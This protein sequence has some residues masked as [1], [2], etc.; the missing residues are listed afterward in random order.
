MNHMTIDISTINHSYGR[1]KPTLCDSELGHHLA[2]SDH[3]LTDALTDWETKGSTCGRKDQK[4]SPSR[5]AW[6]GFIWSQ[7]HADSADIR[8]HCKT[9]SCFKS[10]KAEVNCKDM[11]F[12]VYWSPST[13]NPVYIYNTYLTFTGHNRCEAQTSPSALS[14][15]HP[16]LFCKCRTSRI[17]RQDR[18][19][20][21]ALWQIKITRSPICI[22]PQMLFSRQKIA[23]YKL[24]CQ[25]E[26]TKNDN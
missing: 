13:P 18:H 1:Y 24:E 3:A 26:Y 17:P 23:W 15:S 5:V 21:T 6:K 22:A 14:L 19:G 12:Y 7:H 9:S 25:K 11:F 2:R 8:W 16:D 4:I 20:K 10:S